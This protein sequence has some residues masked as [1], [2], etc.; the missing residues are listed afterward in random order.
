MRTDSTRPQRHIWGRRNP[1]L[2]RTTVADAPFP[3][4]RIPRQPDLETSL[5]EIPAVQERKL[6]SSAGRGIRGLAG[7]HRRHGR[8]ARV[9]LARRTQAVPGPDADYRTGMRGRLVVHRGMDRSAA[10][11]H[12]WPRRSASAGA[13]C[14]LLLDTAWPAA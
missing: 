8:A 14:R 10:V 1:D 11:T 7:R 12:P 9:V 4:P 5:R 6:R 2:R 3:R 13:L